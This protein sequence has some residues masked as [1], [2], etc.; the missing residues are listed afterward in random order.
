MFYAFINITTVWHAM[1]LFSPKES[2]F[3]CVFA[4]TFTTDSCTSNNFAKFFLIFSLCGEIF[5]LCA[6][7]VQS[8]F[9]NSYPASFINRMA[10]PTSAR[11]T[12]CDMRIRASASDKL[13]TERQ[14]HEQVG[15]D[16]ASVLSCTCQRT[17]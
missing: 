11:S 12:D 16:D 13:A 4:L 10:S 8:M 6:I 14:I 5:G 1:L 2:T 15:G 3:S 17:G 7:N 9:P